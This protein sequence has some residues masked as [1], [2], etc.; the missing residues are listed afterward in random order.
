MQNTLHK[1]IDVF[2]ELQTDK[3]HLYLWNT[4]RISCLVKESTS[5]K[6]WA[7]ENN[8]LVVE[9]VQNPEKSYRYVGVPYS[10]IVDLLNADSVGSFVARQIKPNYELG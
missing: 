4:G 8:S 1:K 10:V 3:G 2:T 7:W 6:Y 5:I 9:F